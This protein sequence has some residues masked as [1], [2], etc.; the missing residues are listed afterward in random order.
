MGFKQLRYT[1]TFVGGLLAVAI[2]ACGGSSPQ[3]PSGPSQATPC[4]SAEICVGNW[5]VALDN[6]GISGQLS[7]AGGGKT[8]SGGDTVRFHYPIAGGSSLPQLGALHSTGSFRLVKTAFSHNIYSIGFGGTQLSTIAVDVS[9][10]DLVLRTDPGVTYTIAPALGGPVTV[11]NARICL[12]TSGS[13]DLATEALIDGAA[14]AL[15]CN[16]PNAPFSRVGNSSMSFGIKGKP[17]IDSLVVSAAGVIEGH[18][19]D[20]GSTDRNADNVYAR[21]GVT[22]LTYVVRMQ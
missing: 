20:C 8:L 19:D 17:G 22:P 6:S 10:T 15:P 18:I 3:A 7:V 14:V 21:L 5:R 2:A 12:L 16:P 1:A 9:G 13:V 11:A 4:P